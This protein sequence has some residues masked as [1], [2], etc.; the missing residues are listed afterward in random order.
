MYNEQ[1]YQEE[2]LSQYSFKASRHLFLVHTISARDT[3]HMCRRP[4]LGILHQ[5]LLCQE[6]GLMV[7]RQCSAT[8][9]PDCK[10][11]N[12]IL[13][14]S[15]RHYI[16]GV[17]LFDLCND[18]NKVPSLLVK[19]FEFIEKRA[20]ET[21]EDLYDAYRL[22]ADT[23]QIKDIKQQLNENGVELIQFDRYDL[24]TIAAIVKA[25]L[26]DL[27]NSV[28]PEEIYE[29]IVISIQSISSTEFQKLIKTQ[30][31]P[32]HYNCLSYIMAHL[33]RV[34]NYQFKNRGCRYLPDKLFHIFRFVYFL[35]LNRT[36]ICALN[37]ASSE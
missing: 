5:T 4:F 21:G 26:R 20:F 6:C 18:I 10:L 35:L 15:T 1:Q 22:T 27:Q 2:H 37:G 34:W 8:G 11:S 12:Q 16:F 30:L 3:C 9:L 29:K 33:I 14:M 24:N 7:H 19:A 31:P 13:V 23:N 32:E 17:S 36:A 25:F 28:I